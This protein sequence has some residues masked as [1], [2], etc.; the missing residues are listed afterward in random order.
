MIT[1]I[2]RF[3]FGSRNNTVRT[4]THRAEAGLTVSQVLS[5]FSQENGGPVILSAEPAL[6][7]ECFNA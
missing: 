5:R 2:I 7:A 6:Y 1:Y 4:V 3:H